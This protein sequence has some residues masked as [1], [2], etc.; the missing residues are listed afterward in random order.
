MVWPD[1]QADGQ[2]KTALLKVIPVWGMALWKLLWEFKGHIE[3]GGT[4]KDIGELILGK[5]MKRMGTGSSKFKIHKTRYGQGRPVGYSWS[6]VRG[7][8]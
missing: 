1:G 7:S 3:V 5:T 2:W 8:S 6:M 4:G